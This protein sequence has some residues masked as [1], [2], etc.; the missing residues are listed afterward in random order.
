M[1]QAKDLL[2]RGKRRAK[3][4]GRRGPRRF[5]TVGGCSMAR[6]RVT[7][8][9]G[10]PETIFQRDGL[11]SSRSGSPTLGTKRVL[12][13]S[14]PSRRYVEEV[15]PALERFAPQVFDGARVHVPAEVV[16]AAA[17]KLAR[18][19]PTRSSPSAAAR[20]SASARRCASRTT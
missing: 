3:P 20:R 15:M 2:E 13:I 14:Q 18:A 12:V 8:G 7:S 9:D 5:A 16:E 10:G 4:R 6:R 1:Y 11:G 19:A 17:A